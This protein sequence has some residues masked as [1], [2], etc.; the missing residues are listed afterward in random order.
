MSDEKNM[1]KNKAAR[2][3]ANIRLAVGLGLLSVLI[4]FGFIFL[5]Y[6]KSQGV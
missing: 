5:Q 2:D 6:M 1:E 3:T 4:Y